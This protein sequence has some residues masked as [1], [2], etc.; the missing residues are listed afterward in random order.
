MKTIL[1]A[2]Y[3]GGHINMIIPIFRELKKKKDFQPI[4]L[5]LTTACLTLEEEGISFVS[6]KDLVQDGDE[7]AL[8][9]G[10]KLLKEMGD[11]ILVPKEESIAY[12]GL[13]YKDLVERHGVE[14]AAQAYKAKGRHAFLPL[15]IADRIFEKWTPDLLVAT[16]SP[17][18][19]KALLL[20]SRKHS[21]PS[22]CIIDLFSEKEFQDRLGVKGY[23]NKLCVLNEEVKKR[24]LNYE[25]L[26]KEIAVTGNPAFDKLQQKNL[27]EKAMAYKKSKGASEKQILL[28]IRQTYPEDTDIYTE[29][30]K[31]LIEYAKKKK[32]LHL[33]FR[34][35]PNDTESYSKLPSFVSISSEPASQLPIILQA[36]D[37]V[38]SMNST[39]IMQGALLQ[40]PTVTLEM[41]ASAKNCS[42]ASVQ[43][44]T[45]IYAWEDFEKTLDKALSGNTPIPSLPPLGKATH[46]VCREI[47]KLLLKRE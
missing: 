27:Q 42:F 11:G 10:Q 45:G 26:P 25:R 2:A 30:E 37:T 43:V 28:W 36:S 21:I 16:N 9:Y 7:D 19:E 12:L 29:T 18:T 1:L 23:G 31:R 15:S 22:L 46:N 14:G 4:V 34:R 20:Q 35:H 33:I 47:F 17:K 13:S 32:N 40:K 44:S 41:S 39:V 38:L 8:V 3:G 6:Y 24:L 5:G